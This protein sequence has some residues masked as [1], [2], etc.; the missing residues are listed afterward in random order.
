MN[1]EYQV[2]LLKFLDIELDLK[3]RRERKLSDALFGRE[4]RTSR[5]V[6]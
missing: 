5:Y 1:L 6:G 3:D 4:Q 2:N